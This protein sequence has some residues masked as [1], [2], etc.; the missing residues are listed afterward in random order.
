MAAPRT[1]YEPL[2]T[3]PLT[4]TIWCE[5]STDFYGPLLTGEYLLVIIDKYSRYPVVEIL[6]STSANTVIPVFDKVMSM[7]GIPEV[8]KSDNGPP[9]NS[10]QLH[11]FTTHMS[12]KHRKVTLYWPRANGESSQSSQGCIVVRKSLETRNYR[13]TPH[14][15]TNMSPFAALFGRELK[16]KL[17]ALSRPNAN[18]LIR[19]A[20]DIAK[21]RMKLYADNRCHAKPCTFA[22]GDAV[23]VRHPKQQHTTSNH[24]A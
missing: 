16:L 20:D 23:L 4:E 3:T 21:E 24:I 19:D 10:E 6:R 11:S 17:P 14:T 7:F 22:K 8:L 1:A 2:N 15:T 5:L 13:A 9:F 12:F 18:D